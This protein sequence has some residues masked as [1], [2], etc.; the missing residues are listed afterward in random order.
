MMRWLY[1][2]F[3]LCLVSWRCEEVSAAAGK[4]APAAAKKSLPAA[5]IEDSTTDIIEEV[6][7]KKLDA[8]LEHNSLVAVFF[9]G[10]LCGAEC[11]KILDELEHIDDDAEH[12][13]VQLVKSLDRRYAKNLGISKFPALV[14]FR[15]KQPTV[16]DGDLMKEESV[17]EWLTS[18]SALENP[19]EIEEVNA[20]LLDKLVEENDYVAALFYESHCKQCDKILKELENID[21]EADNLDIAF[22]KIR[23]E[24]LIE[25]Y[26]IE[27]LPALVY[28]RKRI[29]LMYEGD[30]MQEED[31]LD[32]LV[33]QRNLGEDDDIIDEVTPKSLARLIDEKPNLAVLFYD[34]DDKESQRVLHDLET[35]DD[36]CDKKGI[37]FV[38]IDSEQTAKEYGI[39]TI[40]ALVYFE[41]EI[42]NLYEGDLSDEA[43][44]LEWLIYQLTSDEIEDV[45]DEMLDKLIADSKQLAVLFYDKDDRKSEKVL[46]ELEN[47]D[48]DCDKHG[49]PFVKID[50]DAE[51]KEYGIDNLPAL[52]YFENQIPSVYD[53]DLTDED[54][55]LKWLILQ[56]SSDEIED[57]TDRMLE[58]LIDKSKH[59]AVLFYDKDSKSSKTVLAELENIDDDCDKHGINFV[60]IDDDSVA[61]EYGIDTIPSIVYFENE[62]PS[63]YDGDLMNEEKVLEWLVRQVETDEIEDVT[64][65][66]L[67][68]LIKKSSNLAVLFY[69]KGDKLSERVLKE[70]EEI[71]DDCDKNGIQFV[72]IDN[73]EVMKEFGIDAVPTMV[74]YEDGIPSVYEGDLTNE[75]EVLEWLIHQKNEATIE[76]VTDEMLDD[77]VAD[78]E[79]VAVFFTGQN[80]KDCDAVIKEL[81]NIDD[82]TDDHG[83]HFLTTEDTGFA[84]KNGIKNFPALVLF[85]NGQPLTYSG[86]LKDE[87][88]V[89]A[90]LTDDDTYE[91]PDQIEEVN[92]KMLG[93]LLETSDYLAVFFYDENC[94][95]CEKMLVELEH[96]D[97]DADQHE[98][99][100][101]KISDP[102]IAKE[103]G[104]HSLPALVFYRNK[105]P[106]IYDG[107]LND[108]DKVLEWLISYKDSPTD[109][110]ELVDRKM[111][112]M[113]LEDAE[114]LAVFFFEENCDGCDQTLQELE[115][116]DD[117]TDRHG[118]HFV[119]I[120][121]V[122]FAKDLGVSSFPS[123]VYFE[124]RNPSIY[125]GDLSSQQNVLKWLVRRKLKSQTIKN[126]SKIEESQQRKPKKTPKKLKKGDLRKE[127][128]VLDWLVKQKT[129]DTIENINREM[130]NNLVEEKD[131]LA[132][133]FY[134]DNN[135]DCEIVSKHLELIDDDCS[136]FGIE[137]VKMNDPLMAKKYGVR[138]PPGLIFFRKGKH[139]HFKGDLEDEEEVLDWLTDP[140]NLELHDKIEKVNRRMF[141]KM[142]QRSEYLTVIFY[143]DVTCKQCG[144]VLE[145]LENIDDE[146]DSLGIDFVKID[147]MQLAKEYGVFAIPALLFIKKNV[148]P[149]I[150]AGDLKN[151]EKILDWLIS[152]KDPMG[153][154]IEEVAG[155]ILQDKIT[156]ADHVAVLFF[157][158]DD[159][160]ECEQILNELENIDGDTDRHGIQFVKTQ[161]LI[162]AEQFGIKDFPALIYFE[163]Q[164]PNFYE[165]DLLAEEE[166]LAWLIHQR[167]EDTIETVNKDLLE[168][169]V[170]ETQYLA[171]FFYKPNCKAC[172]QALLEL[173]NI[174]DDTD[175]YGIH[176]VKIHDGQLAKRYGIRTYPAL[177]YFRNG[178]PLIYDGDTKNEEAVL[179]W[180]KDEDNRELADEIEAVNKRMLEK[181]MDES[182]FL[183]VFFY[184][185]DCHDCAAALAELENIDDD[186]DVYGIDFVK[187]NDPETAREYNVLNFPSL[188]FFRK[189]EPVIYDGDL[190]DEEKVLS[191]LTSPDI[192][193]IKDEIE[194]VNKK[195][196]DKVLDEND[197]VAVYFYD[198]D[199]PKCDEVLKELENIDDEAEN[200]D[201]AFVKI[202]DSRYA[203]KYGISHLP[204]LVYFRRKFPSIYRGDL[205]AEDEVLEW[206]QKNRYRSPELNL[207]MYA[208]GAITTAFV[209]YT[210]F[211]MFCF[212]KEQHVKTQ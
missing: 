129:E 123:L 26:G 127:E 144:K 29:P 27:A 166:V 85:R 115:N 210:L 192:F 181:L 135:N 72:K 102:G 130:L 43:A 61:K 84:K 1:I 74:Y 66:M 40:P 140:D 173:E 189:R 76:E 119:K 197:F 67:D 38:K 182:P 86:D 122:D 188:V 126:N 196:L 104:L 81:E 207:F 82:D 100:F 161:D 148:D 52:V 69:D 54:S 21:D 10:K 184:D 91:I 83:M 154:V 12:F 18:A 176:M 162:V 60:K 68:T 28:Y 75:N 88:K 92:R 199:C 209:G 164:V 190:M 79:Y 13:G 143:N 56:V 185:R 145:E 169:M 211:L 87:D 187:I 121:D 57:V 65:E 168:H 53:G 46:N 138:N 49:I 36:D 50:N 177:V 153:D 201:I 24:E 70:L 178:N 158:R 25:K 48:D 151:E 131:Y 32:W 134:L 198:G 172:E 77:L 159:C 47:I 113:L 33:T 20:K 2:V 120:N 179:E 106:Q 110:I 171:V 132:V 183:A 5:S 80:C 16:F 118:I 64:D 133:Y 4:K 202:K 141:E 147:D 205:M 160:H 163:K 58:Q 93:K 96:I 51:A 3:I 191:W 142:K 155:D 146:A 200:L 109:V 55:V 108:E 59:L 89:L 175:N 99:D 73:D 34:N 157:K 31:V 42:P 139:V 111:L 37:H 149:V 212:K 165:G 124:D 71:D 116:I 14:Y 35:I 117:D 11:D 95:K 180:L 8:L 195:M 136:E 112:E 78:N 206:L 62:I 103:Y 97:D 98:I 170:A 7:G 203:R 39:D 125:H 174:D 6:E 90:W 41:N 194:E 105:F 94:K 208:L 101:V 9:Y 186:A 30:L 150:Y 107:D 152:Q 204:A 44:V 22:V 137:L 23:D 15:N 19:D 17:L 156:N 114:N 45:T 63:L 167:N 193:V 128:D